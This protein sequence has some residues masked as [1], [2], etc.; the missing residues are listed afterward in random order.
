M[1]DD[2]GSVI[3]ALYWDVKGKTGLSMPLTPDQVKLATAHV[4]RH[5]HQCPM[6]G[7]SA[8]SFGDIVNNLVYQGPSLVIG[9]PTIPMLLVVCRACSYTVQFAAVPIGLVKAG[10]SQP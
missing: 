4:Q 8:W 1:A 9:G 3:D 6:C 2:C 7:S 5:L 10:E